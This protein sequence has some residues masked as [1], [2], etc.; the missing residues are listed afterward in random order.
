[1]I[2]FK[3]KS[4]C[5]FQI[6]IILIISSS[7]SD[8]LKNRQVNKPNLLFI[9]TDEQT[10]KTMKAYGNEFINT[11]N[12]DKLAS[13]GVVFKN[14][15]VSQPVCTPSRSSI[16]TGLYPHQNGCTSNNYPLKDKFKL[17]PELINDTSYR[18]AY[19]GKWHLGDEI[20]RQQGFDEWISIEDNY[21]IYYSEGRD[22]SDRSSYHHYL[23][24]NGFNPN[25][26]ENNIF[27][28]YFATR[29]PEKYSKP[30]F[31]ANETCEFLG[32]N[33]DNPFILYV[34]FLEPHSPIFSVNDRMYNRNE[35][36]LPPNTNDP[37]EDNEPAFY[38]N[39]VS[40]SEKR[41]NN[42]EEEHHRDLVARYYGLVSLVDKSIGV[43]LD[44]LEELKLDEN[45]IVVFT[46]DHGNMLGAHHLMVKSKMFEEAVKVPFIIKAS[47]IKPIVIDHPVNNIQSLPTIMELMNLEIPEYIPVKSLVPLMKGNIEMSEPVFSTW[48]PRNPE[49]PFFR[50]V[51]TTDNNWKLN[52]SDKDKSQLYNLKED[53]FE[54]ANLFYIEEYR[55]IV[56]S[57]AMEIH[58]WQNKTNDTLQIPYISDLISQSFSK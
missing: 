14:A 38:R 36:S 34:N 17:L 54:T 7:C 23:I 15:Y 28:R 9:W 25:D 55:H 41:F 12:L 11:P 27:D 37:L 40:I 50:M 22:R 39:Q 21:T 8:G 13:E 43:I 56:D 2:N 1:M 18:S 10:F 57:L 24:K 29:I 51:V 58:S 32:K 46:S 31:L 35:I 16:M 30:M 48:N 33:K 52:L 19:F 6:I 4:K 5:I 44:K 49:D 45:T 53:P 26:Y 42:F 47:G 3:I 20:Y